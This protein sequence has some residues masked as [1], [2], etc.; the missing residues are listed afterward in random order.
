MKLHWLIVPF[1]TLAVT[2]QAH[3]PALHKKTAEAPNCAAMKGMDHSKMNKD[4]PVMQAMMQ[5]CMQQMHDEQA[6]NSAQDSTGK[7]QK[8]EHGS[9]QHGQH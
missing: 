3:D 6:D 4:D 8:D 9:D 2:A 7:S 5:K 1:L